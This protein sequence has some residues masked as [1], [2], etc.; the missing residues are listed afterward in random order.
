LPLE[1]EL[2]FVLRNGEETDSKA[3]YAKCRE[4]L[5]GSSLSFAEPAGEAAPATPP[6]VIAVPFPGGLKVVPDLTKLIDTEIAAAGDPIAASLKKAVVDRQRTRSSFPPARSPIEESCAWS[7]AYILA[8]HFLISIAW[9][10]VA[11]HGLVVPFSAQMEHLDYNQAWK[12]AELPFRRER[13][14][15]TQ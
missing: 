13:Y 11:I 9:S 4:Y 15:V 7:I 2:H 3:Q 5:A 14:R 8:S 1:S 12:Q 10:T 6:P